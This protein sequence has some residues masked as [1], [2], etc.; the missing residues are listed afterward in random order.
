MAKKSGRMIEL[1]TPYEATGKLAADAPR[2]IRVRRETWRDGSRYVMNHWLP[3]PGRAGARGRGG[4]R[5]AAAAGG[6]A[7]GRRGEI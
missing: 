5:G 1:P 7:V 6:T 3:V 4:G 2:V